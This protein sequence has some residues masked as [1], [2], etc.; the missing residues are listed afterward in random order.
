MFIKEKRP[1]NLAISLNHSNNTQRS[2]LMPVNIHYNLKSIKTVAINY[3]VVLKR[4]ITFE[5]IMMPGVN[6]SRND[7]S[8]LIGFLKGIKCKLNLIPFN[9]HS[10]EF[11]KP[12]TEEIDLFISYLKPLKVPILNRGSM[13]TKVDG[14]C[15]MLALKS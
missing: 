7:A 14:A 4:A 10:N 5:Y 9:S 11:I 13:G 15:G 6:T 3:N 2:K 12:T 8:N 1:Y